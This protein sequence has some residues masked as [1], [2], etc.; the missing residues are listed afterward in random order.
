MEAQSILHGNLLL[1]GW[2]LSGDNYVFTDTPFFVRL[3]VAFWVS[4]GRVDGGANRHLHAYTGR[5]PRRL[6]SI[7]EADAP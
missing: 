4:N 3:R 2:S 6:G 1:S 5:F 7:P